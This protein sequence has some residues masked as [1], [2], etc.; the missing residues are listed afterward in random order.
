MT[1]IRITPETHKRLK[2]FAAEQG[3]TLDQ[4]IISLLDNDMI[5]VT[6]SSSVIV[7]NADWGA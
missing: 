6:G 1:M 5:E 7:T 2:V 3:L 4:A